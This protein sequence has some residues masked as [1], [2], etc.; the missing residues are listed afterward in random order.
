VVRRRRN[1]A[2]ARHR[3]AQ[4]ADVLGHLVPGN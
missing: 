3:V 4:L 2:D 1:Q